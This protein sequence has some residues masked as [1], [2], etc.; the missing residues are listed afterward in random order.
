MRSLSA[1]TGVTLSGARRG[2][3]RPPRCQIAIGGGALPPALPRC[4]SRSR[5]IRS[6]KW[7]NGSEAV[8]PQPGECRLS[9]R[10]RPR[11]VS[12]RTRARGDRNIPAP[13][14]VG[15]LTACPLAAD[16]RRRPWR[17]RPGR[18]QAPAVR[19]RD[20]LR[21]HSEHAGVHR[22]TISSTLHF[23]C[24]TAL[25]PRHSKSRINTPRT[26]FCYIG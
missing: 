11:T 9:R 1:A 7:R 5:T 12:Q 19:G 17:A 25:P 24:T 2:H 20:T 18:G 8:T 4:A 15:I 3:A 21:P 26:V 16:R 22:R 13:S 6:P 23:T 10:E 14:A